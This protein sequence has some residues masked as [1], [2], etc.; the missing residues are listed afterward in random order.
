[1]GHM[2]REDELLKEVMTGVSEGSR[3]RGRRRK[4]VLDDLGKVVVT[5]K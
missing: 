4:S 3:P 2:L 1:M 5:I